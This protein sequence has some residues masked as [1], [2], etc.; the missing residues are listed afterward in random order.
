MIDDVHE[1]SINT[2]IIMGLLK[3]IK[4]KRPDLKLIISSATL[5]ARLLA[6]Y[7]ED[8]KFNLS[9]EVFTIKGRTFNVNINYLSHPVNN[10][11]TYAAKLA[12]NIHHSKPL[13]GDILVFMTGTE[14]I[15][16]FIEIFYEN[17]SKED[18]MTCQLYQLHSRLSLEKQMKVF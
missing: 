4:R 16:A 6:L 12:I 13:N 7:F 8:K 14:E 9:S 3:K 17:I 11:V 5:D 2:D 18:L 1:R 15:E 10:F